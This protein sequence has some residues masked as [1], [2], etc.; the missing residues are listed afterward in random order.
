M[1]DDFFTPPPFKAHD[2]HERL[3]RDLRDMGLQDKGGVFSWRGLS[4]ARVVMDGPN[5]INVALA[6]L[7]ARSPDWQNRTLHNSAELRDWLALVKKNLAIWS[8]R[9][10]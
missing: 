3:R 8:D 1:A 6:R 4:V 9:D 5:A 7:P 10:D 2:G